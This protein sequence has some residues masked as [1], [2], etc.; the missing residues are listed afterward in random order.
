MNIITKY[1][2]L[3]AVS[4]VPFFGG[5]FFRRRIK[6]ITEI[7]RKI[8]LFNLVFLE[9]VVVFYSIWGID[10]D[11]SAL[12]VFIAAFIIAFL[13]YI[14]GRIFSKIL[15]LNGDDSFA[16]VLTSA[17][18][19]TGF[20]MGGF[21][22]FL[23]AGEKAMA[24]SYFCSLGLACLIYFL[25]FP[26]CYVRERG[27]K[28]TL[29][30][31]L[32]GIFRIN[33]FPIIG[34]ILGILFRHLFVRPQFNFPLLDIMV[35]ILVAGYFL[36]LG[37]VFQFKNSRSEKRIHVSEFI[38]KFILVPVVVVGIVMIS[39][40]SGYAGYVIAVESFMPCAVF[41]VVTL[42]LYNISPELS[43]RVFAFNT[44]AFFIFILPL[45][46]LL[47]KKAA[48]LFGL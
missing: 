48:Y 21:I 24:Y 41:S 47:S 43:G 26:L 29:S 5:Y 37:M 42:V 44:A 30:V 14:F 17:M 23:T 18:S 33:N 2:F 1:A 4:I 12:Y 16:F 10:A 28:I 40:I 45:I 25:I 39:G 7:R 38:I 13:G 27:E 15:G 31:F 22:C 19:N 8:I 11:K 32:R 46:L 3:Q 34:F 20:T 36:S 9:P 35:C 6:S